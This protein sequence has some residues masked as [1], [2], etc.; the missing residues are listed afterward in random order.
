MTSEPF[1]IRRQFERGVV[2]ISLDTEQIWGYL[3]LWTERQFER[4]YRDAAG[5]HVRLLAC[6]ERAGIGATWLLVGALALKGSAGARDRRMAGLPDHWKSKVVAGDEGS[7]PLWYRP[8]FVEMLRQSLPRQEIGLHGGL[9][10]LIWT[11]PLA[12]RDAVKWELAEGVKALSRASVQPFS[13]SFGREA[14]AHL[15][16]LPAQGIR[17]YRGRTVSRAFR[18]GPTLCG[19]MARLL[20]ELC[21]TSPAPVWP[22]EVLPGLWRIPASLFLYPIS[23]PRTAI[24]GLQSRIKRFSRGIESAIQHRG[25]FHFCFHP[26]NLCESPDGFLMFEDMLDRLVVSRARG[27]IEVLTMGEVASR[28]EA[29]R[30][31]ERPCP[32]IETFSPERSISTPVERTG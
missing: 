23:R 24:V 19:K 31:I 3:D 18:L 11:D 1:D 7:A 26:E 14:E 27:D 10:H 17:C 32:A 22:D 9:T 5:A 25:I 16:L 13:F 28:M 12:S 6:L 21:R 29:S 8:S 15:D 20:D 4:R 30:N 2:I